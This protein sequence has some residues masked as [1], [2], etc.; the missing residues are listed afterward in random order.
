MMIEAVSCPT[1]YISRTAQRRVQ[2]RPN[3][4]TGVAYFRIRPRRSATETRPAKSRKMGD[5][6]GERAHNLPLHPCVN[7][8]QSARKK[9]RDSL[10]RSGDA[11]HVVSGGEGRRVMRPFRS[12]ARKLQDGVL[13]LFACGDDT[14][15]NEGLV[16]RQPFNPDHKSPQPF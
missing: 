13:R 4:Q 8:S 3:F 9:R 1:L 12:V 11:V 2:C 5:E 6:R 15:E 14:A 16:M 10:T 7:V